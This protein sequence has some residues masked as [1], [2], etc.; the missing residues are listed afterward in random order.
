MR[1]YD[2]IIIGSGPAGLSAG[3][4]AARAEMDFCVIERASVSGGQVLSTYEVDN[5]PGLPGLSGGELA[6]KM[7]EHCEKLGC[8]FVTDEVTEITPGVIASN[9]FFNEVVLDRPDNTGVSAENAAEPRTE[10]LTQPID[11]SR[12][13]YMITLADGEPLLTKTIVVA[14]GASHRL[15]GAEGEEEFTGMGVSYCATC[16]GAFFKGKNVAV[17][18]G[19]D[20]AV[21]D[22]V[23][24]SKMC[25]KVYLIHRRNEFRA[26]KTLVTKARAIENIEFITESVVGRISGSDS[27]EGMRIVNVGT[28]EERDIEVSGVFIAVGITPASGLFR[29]LV[30]CNEGGYI[31]A[32]ESGRTSCPGI[33]AAGDVRKKPL[34]QIVTAAADGANCITSVEGYLI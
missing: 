5:Y 2:T 7:R 24:L 30:A 3:I 13:V 10:N 28:H 14:T 16:D 23:F 33:F 4:Y 1:I 19:G 25:A 32:D 20:V 8:T 22:A 11:W 21:E 9:G 6:Q 31:I 18:G 15:L 17:V 34:R 27:V 12:L 29:N 26:A